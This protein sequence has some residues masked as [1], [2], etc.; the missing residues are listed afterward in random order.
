MM[1]G[2]HRTKFYFGHICTNGNINIIESFPNNYFKTCFDRS[3]PLCFRT[4]KQKYR[5]VSSAKVDASIHK[6]YVILRSVLTACF[7]SKIHRD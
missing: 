1:F 3:E 5:K 4:Q 2:H 6:I 7:I